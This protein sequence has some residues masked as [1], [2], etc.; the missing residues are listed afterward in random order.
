MAELSLSV[1]KL[2]KPHGLSGA[3]RFYLSRE[4]KNKNKKPAHFL[5]DVNGTELPFFVKEIEWTGFNEGFILFEE[6]IT[7]EKA[8]AYSGKELRLKQND[9]AALFKTTAD[10][11]DFLKGYE[12]VEREAG[13]LGIIEEVIENPGQLLISIKTNSNEMLIPLA[14]EFVLKIDKRKKELTLNLPEGLLAL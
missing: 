6:I 13:K 5:L 3:F 14:D 10:E 11:Y 9:I 4:L 12:V 8:K 7:P 2:G 1:G